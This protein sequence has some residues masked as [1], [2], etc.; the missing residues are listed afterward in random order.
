[1][2]NYTFGNT[3]YS[4]RLSKHLSQKELG[5]ATGFCSQQS[6][7]DDQHCDFDRDDPL[8]L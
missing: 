6:Q 5:N 1:M 4:L 3:V 8:G 2:K 7:A